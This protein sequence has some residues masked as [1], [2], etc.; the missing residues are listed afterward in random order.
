MRL[1]VFSGRKVYGFAGHDHA[2]DVVE[3]GEGYFFGGFLDITAS[4][5]EGATAK[6]GLH[7]VGRILGQSCRCS[8][9]VIWQQYF[10]GTKQ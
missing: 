4:D 3:T 5:G 6:G 9:E 2:Y 1:V 7:G 10:G 8:G